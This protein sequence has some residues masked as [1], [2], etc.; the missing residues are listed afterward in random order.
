[1]VVPFI[2]ASACATATFAALGD[3]AAA[4]SED[5]R[6]V[7]AG[8]KELDPEEASKN[9][10]ALTGE[11]TPLTISNN[12]PPPWRVSSVNFPEDLNTMDLDKE[13][14]KHHQNPS[15]SSPIS[16]GR[17]SCVRSI[18]SKMKTTIEETERRQ[19]ESQI[20]RKRRPKLLLDS[21]M[22]IFIAEKWWMSSCQVHGPWPI[23]LVMLRFWQSV[24]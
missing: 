19:Y 11:P 17:P 15:V 20:F 6:D 13:G 4:L 22:A 16:V 2:A 24:C 21:S 14:S 3:C 12:L 8:F 1:M 7:E 23:T 10:L 5:E 9:V 18:L